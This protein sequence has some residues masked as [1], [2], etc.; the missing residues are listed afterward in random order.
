MSFFEIDQQSDITL[1]LAEVTA[2]RHSKKLASWK[3]I[4]I[5]FQSHWLFYFMDFKINFIS[6]SSQRRGMIGV[7]K[8]NPTLLL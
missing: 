1:Y 2:V 3:T 7:L 8:P 4:L 6:P 5:Y